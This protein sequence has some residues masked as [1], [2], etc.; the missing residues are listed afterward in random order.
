MIK[1]EIYT[2]PDGKVTAFLIS[3]HSSSGGPGY[4]VYCAEISTLSY[5]ARICI[6][7]HLNRDISLENFEHGGL[8]IELENAPDELTE[9]VFQTMLIGMRHVEQNAPQVLKIEFIEMDTSTEDDLQNQIKNMSQSS[10]NPLPKF[11]VPQVKIRADIYKSGGKISG[12]TVEE[13][14]N[15]DMDELKI[16]CAGIWSLAR[17]AFLCTKDYLKRAIDFE[18]VEGCL[19]LKLKTPPDDLTEAVFQMML[20]GMREI[21]NLKP[22]ALKIVVND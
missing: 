21:E 15:F 14:K 5:A 7:Q 22:S 11:E 8:G 19:K 20:L 3:G 6:K 4:D 10:G 16:Y 9:A 2:Q 13:N 18:S 1:A 12:F 17:S